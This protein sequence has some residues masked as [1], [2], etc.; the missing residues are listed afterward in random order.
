MVDYVGRNVSVA[1]CPVRLSPPENHTVSFT[2]SEQVL[3][4]SY[5]YGGPMD[6][7]VVVTEVA[8]EV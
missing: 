5:T 6:Q 4:W 7:L 1:G 2:H 8:P 3:E